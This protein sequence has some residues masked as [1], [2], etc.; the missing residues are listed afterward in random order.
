MVSHTKL[1]TMKGC[2]LGG[3]LLFGRAVVD[4]VVR[5]LLVSTNATITACSTENNGKGDISASGKTGQ[6]SNQDKGTRSDSA[7]TQSS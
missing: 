1:W 5:P 4:C 7:R 3:S 2:A 6:L